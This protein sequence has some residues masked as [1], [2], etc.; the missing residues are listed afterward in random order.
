M[1][2]TQARSKIASVPLFVERLHELATK[3]AHRL[4]KN[5]AVSQVGP[6]AAPGPGATRFKVFLATDSPTVQS[7][8]MNLSLAHQAKADA[9]GAAVWMLPFDPPHLHS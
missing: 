7:M 8:Y 5:A 3:L 6:S 1:F 4:V 2:A 9:L